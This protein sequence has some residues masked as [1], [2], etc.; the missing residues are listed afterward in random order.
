MSTR[1]SRNLAFLGQGQYGFA[2]GGAIFVTGDS[3]AVSATG[4]YFS[5][6]MAGGFIGS[7]N[8]QGIA[9]SGGTGDDVA[10]ATGSFSTDDC[11]SGG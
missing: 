6:N 3:T 4:T 10:I 2:N 9:V 8:Y 1:V 5:A 7:H 11:D